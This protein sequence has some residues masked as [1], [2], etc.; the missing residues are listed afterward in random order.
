MLATHNI[1]LE[2]VTLRPYNSPLC[3]FVPSTNAEN[4]RTESYIC[5]FCVGTE[6][7]EHIM[8]GPTINLF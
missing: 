2:G 6:L 4:Q 5:G 3:R 1:H 8:E 7:N